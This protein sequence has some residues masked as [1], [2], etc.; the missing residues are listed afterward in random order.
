MNKP[1]Y[2]GGYYYYKLSPLPPKKPA[3][4]EDPSSVVYY[5]YGLSQVVSPSHFHDFQT[6]FL[7]NLFFGRP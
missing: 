6:G 4:S 7:V 3:K 5:R 2:Y 1:C